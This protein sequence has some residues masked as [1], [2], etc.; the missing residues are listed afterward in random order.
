MDDPDDDVGE[1]A[2]RTRFEATYRAHVRA[3]VAFAV[4]RTAQPADAADV[5]AETF[6]V[7]WRRL[8]DVPQGDTGRLWLYGVARGV[9]ANQR[10]GIRRRAR[11]GA[12]LAGAVAAHLVVHDHAEVTGTVAVVRE[13]LATLPAADREVL[14]LVAW[15]GLTA[16]QIGQLLGIPAATVRS[17][18]HR[19]RGRLRAAV[20]EL[21][22][23]GD[24]PPPAERQRRAGHE[25][26]DE[27][28][29]AWDTE[30]QP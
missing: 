10:R 8:D 6:L 1:R 18:L 25:R 29:L 5:V 23:H 26:V 2:R 17:R 9:M 4:R 24:H 19:A 3:I 12:R 14:Q 28:A 21:A 16:A 22:T 30:G 27:R 20:R 7:A 15:E 11:L 13:A